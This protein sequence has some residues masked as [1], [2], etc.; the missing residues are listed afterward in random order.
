MGDKVMK[1]EMGFESLLAVARVQK[2]E[3]ADTWAFR[4]RA[5]GFALTGQ[6]YNQEAFRHFLSLEQKRAERLSRSFLLL[7]VSLKPKTEDGVR[8]AP[9]AAAAV[10]SGLTRSVRDVDFIGWY[11]EGSVAAAVLT[12]GAEAPGP[13]APR[14]IR[15]RVTNVLR[16]ELRSDI[17]E[18]LLVRVRPLRRRSR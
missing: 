10:F 12:Q 5:S 3:G 6:V 2:T 18:R 17:A 4:D 1:G 15:D 13:D 9:V 7:M 8:F 14:Q 11:R 16:G